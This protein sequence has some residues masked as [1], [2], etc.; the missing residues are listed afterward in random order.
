MNEL[1]RSLAPLGSDVEVRKK[2]LDFVSLTKKKA[3]EV[4]HQTTLTGAGVNT[5]QALTNEEEPAMSIIG[6]SGSN[7]IP[8][9][10]DIHAGITEE[11]HPSSEQW[12]ED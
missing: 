10:V 3:S 4:R 1:L 6:F 9:G 8:R 11:G 7:V 2:W 12:Q 5:A